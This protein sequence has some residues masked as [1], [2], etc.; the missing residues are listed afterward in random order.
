[1]NIVDYAELALDLHDLDCKKKS[2]HAVIV[3]RYTGRLYECA[4]SRQRAMHR[5]TGP[6]L[7]AGSKAS[8]MRLRIR[9]FG[10]AFQLGRRD[11]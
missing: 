3:H 8:Y 7:E 11:T 2:I 5:F 10:Y 1:M 9:W 4:R 6:V